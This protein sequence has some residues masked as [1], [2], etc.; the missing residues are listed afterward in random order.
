MDKNLVY[1]PT[2]QETL[3]E[4]HDPFVITQQY[5]IFSYLELFLKGLFQDVWVPNAKSGSV[6]VNPREANVPVSMENGK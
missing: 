2:V 4:K 1:S 6:H 3:G 5:G